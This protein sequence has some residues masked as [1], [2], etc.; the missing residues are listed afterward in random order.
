[1]DSRPEKRR[2]LLMG[3]SSACVV[4]GFCEGGCVDGSLEEVPAHSF[5]AARVGGGGAVSELASSP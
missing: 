5:V 3:S 1:M 2:V 4:G